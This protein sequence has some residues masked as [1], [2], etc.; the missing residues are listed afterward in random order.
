MQ[1]EDAILGL[2]KGRPMSGYDLKKLMVDSPYMLWSGNNNQVYRA[3][4]QLD[5]RGLVA[6]E[7]VH[8]EG[9]PSRKVYSLTPAGESALASWLAAALPELPELRK[10]FL[11]QLAVAART[12]PDRLEPLL[13]QYLAEVEAQHRMAREQRRRLDRLEDRDRRPDPDRLNESG[14][15]SARRL[16]EAAIYDNIDRFYAAE[17]EW[18]R[19]VL[20]QERSRSGKGRET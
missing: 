18:A 1:I 19:S 11:V 10:P 2:L 20:E 6:C 8:R 13:R 5:E 7:T 12:D 9:A 4:L 15:L 14:G 3:L 17:T 16:V